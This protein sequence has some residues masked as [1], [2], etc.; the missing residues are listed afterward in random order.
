LCHITA[1]GCRSSIGVCALLI[2]A[3]IPAP[4]CSVSMSGRI[5]GNAGLD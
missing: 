5:A 3:P 4:Y 1:R 2:L